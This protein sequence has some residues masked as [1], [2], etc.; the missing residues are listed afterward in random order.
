MEITQIAQLD[1][2]KNYTY[3]DYLS[4]K[5]NER[6]ELL[7]GKVL[8]MSPASATRHQ[9][10]SMKISTPL[11]YFLSG[12]NCEIFYAPFDVRLSKSSNDSEVNTV[13]QPDIC[14]I[15]DPSKIDERGCKGAPDLIIEILSPGN[16]T[17]EMKNKFELYQEAGVLE[18]WIVE[19]EK[20]VV[21]QYVLENGIYTNHKPLT[22]EDKI[23]SFV[24]KG[25]SLDLIN[26]F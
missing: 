9:R 18:Y 7:K 17:K 2:S 13:V 25:F 22:T 11:I 4:W 21:L 10:L 1:L 3:L 16:S 23:E 6:V 5:F 26:V 12:K 15:C 20:E 8:K 14:V 24:L 19:P